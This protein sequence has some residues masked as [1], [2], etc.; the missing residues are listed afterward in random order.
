AVRLCHRWVPLRVPV[1]QPHRGGA[2]NRLSPPSP[3]RSDM[4]GI[5]SVSM[6]VPVIAAPP[7]SLDVAVRNTQTALNTAIA[8]LDANGDGY[9]SEAESKGLQDDFQKYY[10]ASQ[11]VDVGGD[12]MVAVAQ[13]RAAMPDRVRFSM[14]IG[15]VMGDKV[16]P[17][18]VGNA[19]VVKVADV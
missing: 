13:L 2:E 15:G 6:K 12:P 10:E 4:A 17:V 1:A 5:G 18:L 14:I 16:T 19:E 11:M 7:V 9:L 3:R 8:K